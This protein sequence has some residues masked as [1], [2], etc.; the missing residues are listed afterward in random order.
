MTNEGSSYFNF[1][2]W[3]FDVKNSFTLSKSCM[4][5]EQFLLTVKSTLFF[6]DELKNLPESKRKPPCGFDVALFTT[7]FRVFEKLCTVFK[8]IF[9]EE[10]LFNPPQVASTKMP[11]NKAKICQETDFLS[12]GGHLFT[13]SDCFLALT[14]PLY[15][16][17]VRFA[18]VL[19]C[20]W[21]ILP[22]L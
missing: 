13:S 21:T 3:K 10:T 12:T 22:N 14:S 7:V 4:K 17:Q 20:L 8:F 11:R 5:I 15:V 1:I 9:A 19:F 2:G 16:V 18:F 6:T